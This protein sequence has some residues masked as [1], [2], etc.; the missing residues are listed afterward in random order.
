M[1]LLTPFSGAGAL[2]PFGGSPIFG[3]SVFEDFPMVADVGTFPSA[4]SSAAPSRRTHLRMSLVENPS[5]Y[6][7][8]VETPGAKKEDIK[9]NANEERLTINVDH[10]EE[11]LGENEV[12]R[13]SDRRAAE[14]CSRT[15]EMP[16]DVN[17]SKI[18]AKHESGMLI[19]TLPKTSSSAK[20]MKQISIG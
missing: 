17:T 10:K 2:S 11:K 4:L 5:S 8:Y 16:S 9:L 3:S 7:M 1:S 14:H 20:K 18:S 15:M 6:I 12:L 19:V 13:W